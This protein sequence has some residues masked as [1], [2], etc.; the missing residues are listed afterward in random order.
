MIHYLGVPLI[1]FD[2]SV[3]GTLCVL[4]DKTRQH[5]EVNKKL[6]WHL[7]EIIEGDFRIF[8]YSKELET[9]N[10]IL[11]ERV[12]E[13]TGELQK[14]NE[15]LGIQL[16]EIKKMEHVLRELSIRDSLTGLFNRRYM[17]ETLQQELARASRKNE[18]LSI[19]MID[20]DTLKEI[21]DQYGHIE[22]GDKTLIT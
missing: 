19:V 22:G 6:L 11:E 3:F 16:A 2:N 8:G 10:T 7:K 20:I 21:N 1:W 14:A 13:R 5:S 15:Q 18:K 17:E 4:D 9:S 12:K